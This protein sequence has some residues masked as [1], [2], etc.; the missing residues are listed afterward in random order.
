M[1]AEPEKFYVNMI[2]LFSI[3]L[4]AAAMTFYFTC[5]GRPKKS[6]IPA[7]FPTPDPRMTFL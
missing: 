6:L 7:I 5:A 3:I 1:S 2:D 4:P